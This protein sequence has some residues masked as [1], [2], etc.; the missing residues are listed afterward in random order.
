MYQYVRA[1][2][3]RRTRSQ[4][5]AWVGVT[6]VRHIKILRT[7]VEREGR[8]TT[9]E[10]KKKDRCDHEPLAHGRFFSNAPQIENPS[11]LFGPPVC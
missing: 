11:D 2:F 6:G 3:N 7:A 1:R 9:P 10:D 5:E 4:G 8:S